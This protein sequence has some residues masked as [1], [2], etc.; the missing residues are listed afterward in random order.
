MD[1]PFDESSLPTP[2]NRPRSD[3][4]IHLVS[5]MQAWFPGQDIARGMISF[6]S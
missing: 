1:S 2:L 3:L 5:T 4:L 6:S